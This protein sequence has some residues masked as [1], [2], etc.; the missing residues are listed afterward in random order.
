MSWAYRLEGWLSAG[1]LAIA[2]MNYA[3]AGPVNANGTHNSPDH[4]VCLDGQRHFWQESAVVKGAA[5][6]EHETHVVC[7]AKGVYWIDTA[8]LV[9]KHGVGA[10]MLIRRRETARRSAAA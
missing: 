5:S 9:K 7:S 10:I 6:F 4:F 2:Q 3:G 1:W 8:D